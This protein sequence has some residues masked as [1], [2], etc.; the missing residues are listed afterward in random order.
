MAASRSSTGAHAG[1]AG[2][3]GFLQHE[4]SSDNDDRGMN[5][6]ARSTTLTRTSGATHDQHVGGIPW[7]ATD[8]DWQATC[9][10]HTF[11]NDRLVPE[12]GKNACLLQ[13]LSKSAAEKDVYSSLDAHLRSAWKKHDGKSINQ[14]ME[15][16]LHVPVDLTV[17]VKLVGFDGDGYGYGQSALPCVHASGRPAFAACACARA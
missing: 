5:T 3:L 9:M 8:N 11:S 17:H 2:W 1:F 13:M 15:A 10:A 4:R 12:R 6:V 16:L 14:T 7:R